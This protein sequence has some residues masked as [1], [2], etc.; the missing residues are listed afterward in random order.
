MK[1]IAITP[2]KAYSAK[3]IERD[4]P[5]KDNNALVKSIEVGICG[6]DKE[7]Y[8]GL[9]GSPPKRESS[10]ILGHE[11]LGRVVEVDQNNGLE[12]GQLVVATVRRPCYECLPCEKNESDKCYSGRF[13]ERGI[14]GRDGFLAEYWVEDPLYL[15]PV[16]E[17]LRE[18]GVLL[19][20]MSVVEKAIEETYRK[21]DLRFWQ[22]RKA[23]VTGAGAIGQIATMI[24]RLYGLDVNT[25]A[26][27]SDDSLKADLVRRVGGNYINVLDRSL[28]EIG[29]RLGPFDIIIEATGN[30]EVAFESLNLLNSNGVLCWTSVT[31]GDKKKVIP[32]ERL[33]YEF[34]LGNKVAFGMVNSNR[35]HFE[36]GIEHMNEIKHKWPGA[37]EMMITRKIEFPHVDFQEIGEDKEAIKTVV[38]F[39]S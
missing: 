25:V 1:A 12:V 26:T 14:G 27:R 28:D 9:Y 4:I 31:G 19:E 18:V 8:Q 24:L 21:Q 16:P 33:N 37:L 10:L 3:V 20:P 35:S 2:L 39:P 38:T 15:I 13:T 11:S 34:V 29:S 7:I 30:A 6:T 5:S 23:L 22:P 32:I 17:H 36:K